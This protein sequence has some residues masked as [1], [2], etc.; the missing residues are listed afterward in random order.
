MLSYNILKNRI[1]FQKYKLIR[2]IGK[3]SF[4]YV[5]KGVNLQDNS[6]VAI[7]AE[8]KSSIY[9]LLEAECNFLSILKGYGIPEVKSYGYSN[10][11]YFLVE[12]LL[13][14]NLTEVRESI[15]AFSLKD[16]VMIAIQSLERIEF[17]HSRYIIHR[18]IKPENFLLGYKNN[19]IIYLIDFGMSRKYKSSRTGKHLKYSLTGKL[20]G[21]FR[22]LSYNASRGVE[23]SRRD[24]LESVG[25]MLVNLRNGT[26][27]WTGLNLKGSHVKKKYYQ[28]VGLKRNIKPEDLCKNLPQ[29]FADYVRYCR[30][31][32][33]EE[34]PDYNYLIN[35]FRGLLIKMKEN[36]DS[37]FTWN[38]KLLFFWNKS[39]KEDKRHPNF[40][41]RKASPH[42]RLFKA[43][44][45]SFNSR[46]K[47]KK[48]IEIKRDLSFEG[49]QNSYYRDK[50]DNLLEISNNFDESEFNIYNDN[51]SFDSNNAQFNMKL[52]D[53]QSL[54]KIEENNSKP[55]KNILNR[56]NINKEDKSIEFQSIN[57]S[58]NY[59]KEINKR[60]FNKDNIKNNKNINI[61][62]NQNVSSPNRIITNNLTEV[63]KRSNNILSELNS[64]N[65]IEMVTPNNTN[66]IEINKNINKSPTNFLLKKGRFILTKPSIYKSI[67]NNM[68]NNNQGRDFKISLMK[69]IKCSEYKPIYSRREKSDILC[70]NVDNSSNQKT[71]AQNSSFFNENK[72]LK[73]LRKSENII[74]IEKMQKSPYQ[75]SINNIYN[76]TNI[77]NISNDFMNSYAGQK[78]KTIH[79]SN[80]FKS[81]NNE[82]NF[83]LKYPTN[84]K[85]K[86]KINF[87]RNK[88]K[89]KSF[90]I[91]QKITMNKSLEG[92]KN[93]NKDNY[94][95]NSKKKNLYS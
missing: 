63:N 88:N 62:I 41:K 67:F 39:P 68:P 5:F 80:S 74:S 15:K 36:N 71:I 20:F 13:G 64:Y 84:F 70:N 61:I 12:E 43:I 16:I 38:K 83:G 33:F 82:L 14:K 47:R 7:K 87:F 91:S 42:S 78:L 35:L 10:N 73:N 58:K 95:V 31:L 50:S 51:S 9:H 28:S 49:N 60:K 19:S 46:E 85:D 93:L 30:N 27:P 2:K 55:K 21:T 81:D 32:G 48:T 44:K 8:K 90:P 11:F 53:F 45:S 34:D 40:Y 1:L 92:L 22:Y 76:N 3:G 37:N 26:L 25:Y 65:K 66:F 69:K 54:G 29:E 6:E 52:A 86:C 72:E 75:H 94:K 79:L 77:Y 59:P 17:I 57:P 23:Q 89:L 24:D 4:G 18:D 56:I